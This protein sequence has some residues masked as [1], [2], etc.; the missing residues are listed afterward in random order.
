M[1]FHNH[2]DRR[3]LTVVEIVV[4]L[5]CLGVLAA[6]V[7][8]LIYQQQQ[9]QRRVT[10][11][12]HLRSVTQAVGAYASFQQEQLPLLAEEQWGWPVE[13]LPYVGREELH[14]RIVAEESTDAV[15]EV[16]L[17]V[18][19]CPQDDLHW[20]KPGGLS[21]AANSG[22]GL[23]D[24]DPET[25]LVEE[26]GTHTAAIDLDGDGEVSDREL[27]INYSTGVFWRPGPEDFRMTLEFVRQ[28]DGLEQTLMLAEN[29]NAGWW[30]S[31]ET[32]DLAFVIGREAL[33]FQGGPAGPTPLDIERIEPGP[34]AP[35]AI[36]Q[37]PPG[38]APRPSAHL[39]DFFHAARCGGAAGPMSL[40]IDPLVY[41]RLLTSNGTAYGEADLEPGLA[42]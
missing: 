38:R 5:V 30:Y 32:L 39:D 24:V 36:P 14:A 15:R 7:V 11:L 16:F 28:G 4:I 33:A 9:R 8:P 27:A 1:R 13:L 10:C 21:Y 6:I 3:G 2:K 40:A 25:G 31:A 12:N 26:T 23:F 41:A 35:G 37:A 20:Q 19:A 29:H 22:Y 17:P 42:P 18:F 34:F